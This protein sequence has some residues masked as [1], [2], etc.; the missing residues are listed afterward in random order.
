MTRWL[1]NMWGKLGESQHDCRWW[2]SLLACSLNGALRAPKSGG[3]CTLIPDDRERPGAPPRETCDKGEQTDLHLPR[4]IFFSNLFLVVLISDS[5]PGSKYGVSSSRS[6]VVPF[7]QSSP[8]EGELARGGSGIATSV[9]KKCGYIAY[10]CSHD[11][12]IH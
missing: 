4:K 5:F 10:G 3:G 6:L 9:P 2:V 8:G 11:A 7:W 1:V 12:M